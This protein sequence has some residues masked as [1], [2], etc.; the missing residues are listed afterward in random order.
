L[1]TKVPEGFAWKIDN[2]IINGTGALQP[3]GVLESPALITI[4]EEEDQEA[5]TIV[6]MNIVKMWA[7][8]YGRGQNKAIWV[9]SPSVAT[10]LM[11]MQFPGTGT[12]V[13]VYIPPSG[14]PDSPYAKLLGRPVITTEAANTLGDT[15]DIIL[16]D[17]T[18]YMTVTKTAG[19][20]TDVSMHL[21]FEYDALAFRF[22]LRVG[23]KPWWSAPILGKDGTTK[24][25]AFV[26]LPDREGSA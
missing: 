20:R 22:L 1:S 7:A 24:Y 2:A 8:L 14:L 17:P 19:M 21:F 3:L 16:M 4:D 15:G 11:T 10:Q 9:V 5:D 13:P 12:A 25:S 26:T 6:F 18:K 23:G